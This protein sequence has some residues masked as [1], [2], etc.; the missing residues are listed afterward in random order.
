MPPFDLILKVILSWPVI[1]VAV[2]FLLYYG[3][4]STIVHPPKIK[5]KAAVK[6]KPPAKPPKDKNPLPKNADT[7]Q[8]GL[9]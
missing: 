9:E 5:A 1:V 6:K 4:V 8:L 2:S 3:L 7:G